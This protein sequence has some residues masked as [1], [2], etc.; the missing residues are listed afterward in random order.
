MTVSTLPVRESSKSA[1]WF[2]SVREAAKAD[3]P[4]SADILS[5][6]VALFGNPKDATDAVV[7]G[8]ALVAEGNA[9]LTA[10]AAGA[11]SWLKAAALLVGHVSAREFADATGSN[12]NTLGRLARAHD[13]FRAAKDN[14]TPM[15]LGRAISIGNKVGAGE[16]ASMIVAY[17][18]AD[19]GTDPFAD[20][21][22]A[23]SIGKAAQAKTAE[24]YVTR[25]NGLGSLLSD[26]LADGFPTPKAETLEALKAAAETFDR[27]AKQHATLTAR[28][29]KAGKSP[30]KPDRVAKAS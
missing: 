25:L 29:A 7:K 14:K 6:G 9:M 26:L 22:S 4:V 10:N 16:V 11:E 8:E 15:T 28:V 27:M 2:K 20:A 13:V 30:A 21:G 24:Q 5:A 18:S 12:P 19:E 23:T 1:D 3:A 17:N